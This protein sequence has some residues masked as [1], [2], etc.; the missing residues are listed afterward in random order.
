MIGG[1]RLLA[2]GVLGAALA[3]LGISA[4]LSAVHASR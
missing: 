3:G 2:L 4:Y 1:E